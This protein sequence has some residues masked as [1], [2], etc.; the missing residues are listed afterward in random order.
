MVK[1]RES[2]HIICHL[3]PCLSGK[4][5]HHTI[6]RRQSGISGRRA[7]SL[8]YKA[9]QCRPL[10]SPLPLLERHGSRTFHYPNKI[11]IYLFPSRHT[12]QSP[13]KAIDQADYWTA[14]FQKAYP[15]TP[16][17]LCSHPARWRI[18]VPRLTRALSPDEAVQSG[19]ADTPTPPD[20]HK[21]P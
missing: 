1:C 19:N 9:F 4:K 2:K 5:R 15:N 8:S 7:R 16:K 17:T 13:A 6:A 12:W 21:T 3:M 11:Q 18:Q 10:I 20:R 14:L